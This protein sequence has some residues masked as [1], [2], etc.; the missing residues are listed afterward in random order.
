ME[1]SLCRIEISRNGDRFVGRMQSALGG[2][3]EYSRDG[4]DKVLNQLVMELL[5]EFETEV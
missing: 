3:R 1:E 2:N 4:F 5:D